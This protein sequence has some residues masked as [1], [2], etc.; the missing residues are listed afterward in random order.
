MFPLLIIL[1]LNVFSHCCSVLYVSWFCLLEHKGGIDSE[2]TTNSRKFCQPAHVY[3]FRGRYDSIVPNRPSDSLCQSVS[4]RYHVSREARFWEVCCV[5]I[6]DYLLVNVDAFE[7]CRFLN[8]ILFKYLFYCFFCREM[9]SAVAYPVTLSVCTLFVAACVGCSF[10]G[11]KHCEM[12]EGFLMSI[13]IVYNF[14][15]LAIL[16]TVY[17]PCSY[18]TYY[19]NLLRANHHLLYQREQVFCLVLYCCCSQLICS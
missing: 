1:S 4:Q 5:G 18:S 19:E 12:Y 8:F 13:V 9:I 2:S 15:N 7:T 3:T 14:L 16:P 17:L 11:T 10:G 6:M